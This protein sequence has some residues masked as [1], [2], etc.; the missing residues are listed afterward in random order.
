MTPDGRGHGLMYL[1]YYLTPR[2]MHEDFVIEPHESV[3]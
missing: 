3:C 1:F 2:L